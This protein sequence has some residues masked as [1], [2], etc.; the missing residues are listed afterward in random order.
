VYDLIGKRLAD[1]LTGDQSYFPEE[2]KK[3]PRTLSFDLYDLIASLS[4]MQART[5]D[6]FNVLG[7]AIEYLK[8][9]V[10]RFDKVIEQK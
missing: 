7:Q 6:P 4:A 5:N 1:T 2:T 3:D 8:D 10:N 9:Q